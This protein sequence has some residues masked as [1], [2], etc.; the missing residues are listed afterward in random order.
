M[1][2]NHLDKRG[3]QW[4][5]HV[6]EQSAMKKVVMIAMIAVA[7]TVGALYWL[8]HRHIPT[9]PQ[10]V[11]HVITLAGNGT[12]GVNDGPAKA[13][14]FSD[15]FGIAIDADG[16]VIVADGGDSNRIRRITPQGQVE[17]LA[18][19]IEGYADG[20]ATEAAFNTP[21]G[22]APDRDGNIIIA[23]TA[24]NRIRRLTPDGQVST[25]AGSGERGHRDG[26]AVRAQFDGP[27]GIAVTDDGALIVA[28]SYN[29][30]IRRISLDGQV[31][32][33]AG[34]GRPGFRDGPA[35]AAL[36]DTPCGVAVDGQGNVFV[37]DTGNDAIRKI[38]LQ[39]EVVTVVAG[40]ALHQ[41]IGI[42]VTHDGFLF[43][44]DSNGV[45]RITP[46]GQV[47]L[48]AGGRAGFAD[49][50]GRRARFGRPTGCAVDRRGHVVV[51]DTQNYVIRRVTPVVP[52]VDSV[53]ALPFYVQPTTDPVP[54]LPD[55]VLPRIG[56]T[57]LN[58]GTTF[59]WPLNPS[60]QWREITGVMGEARGAP[61]QVALD[62][63]HSGLDIRGAWGEPVVCVLNEKVSDPLPAWGFDESHEGIRLGL[64][65]YIH[66]YVGRDADGQLL[67]SDR[68][69]PQL[70]EAGQLRSVRVR[71][72]T[73]FHVGD[74]IGTINR[75][76]HLHL[77]VGPRYAPANP[78]QFP[79]IALKDT[80]APIIEPDSLQIIGAD[81]QP[82]TAKRDGRL[83]LSGDVD[84][85]VTAYDRMDGNARHRKLGV[86][87][88]GYQLLTEAGVPL[89]G[90]EQPLIN[91]EFN[92]LPPDDENVLLVYAP[93]SGVSAYGT[94]TTFRYIVTNRVRDGRAQDGVLRISRLAPGLYRLKVIVQDY[95]GNQA[96]GQWPVVVESPQTDGR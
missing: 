27:I 56:V 25:L 50:T 68:F 57:M 47:H 8:S 29:D 43:V 26:P 75:L 76:Y 88:A 65:S 77:N 16:N 38:T 78:L 6:I 12:A 33:L 94:P 28:D 5:H 91:L 31:S 51:A 1:R 45:H 44:T 17:T 59:P 72:G 35:T 79:F 9:D 52:T 34:A 42:A 13:A 66:I 93:G 39:G 90:F 60:N 23:D 30:R 2:L 15:P 87:K 49:G 19:A 70:D 83:V 14:Q 74:V 48:F 73:R 96:S 67:S 58:I 82:L 10:A 85:V 55:D 11:G 21:S 92:R 3:L 37:A 40:D 84:I 80:V 81:G 53:D 62:H 20:Q 86:Y 89:S 7:V 24:N 54:A 63:L 18:G 61:N 41:P 64:I 32:T 4:Q 22:V 36:F 95:A 46:E 69:L 71:R